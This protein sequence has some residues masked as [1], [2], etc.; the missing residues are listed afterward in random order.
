MG[1]LQG[2]DDA[3]IY[4]K[5]F[6]LELLMSLNDSALL[7]PPGRALCLC[8]LCAAAALPA[9]T[10]DLINHAGAFPQTKGS[11]FTI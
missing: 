1:V 6:V 3:R 5:Q 9:C 7:A 11:T 10:R 4:R 8:T 2:V